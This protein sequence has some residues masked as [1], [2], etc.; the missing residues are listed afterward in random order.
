[1]RSGGLE[2]VECR[3]PNHVSTSGAL[4]DWWGLL[5]L[6]ALAVLPLRLAARPT[7]HP[8]A[9]PP[10][11]A[12]PG[13]AS[14][15]PATGDAKKTE[16][17]LEALKS[18]IERVA[19]QVSNDEVEKSRLNKELR[20]ADVSVGKARQ[21]LDGVRRQRAETAARRTSLAAEKKERESDL[22][23]ERDALAAQL[24]AAYMIGREEPLKLLLN[25]KDP[26]R[27]GR[28]FAYYGYFGRAR[29]GQIHEIEDNVQ[30]LAQLDA[31]LEAE[32]GK[33]AQLEKS[34]R[35]QLADLEEARQHRSIVLASLE[36]EAHTRAE[37]LE[38]LRTQQAGLEKLLKELRRALEKLPTDTNDA[39]ARLRG[40]LAWPVS[41]RVLAR[42]GETR[43]GGVKWDGVL[44]ATERGAPVRA[45]SPGRVIY[46]DWLPGLGLLTII[47][48][49]NGYMSL[50]GHNE[51]L[52]KAV[53]EQVAAGDAIASAGDSGGT[54]RPELYFE[55]RKAGRP[56]DPRPW[57]KDSAP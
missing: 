42:F 30:S 48:H 25:Q 41:G 40:K 13:P 21:G 56:I 51:Q 1:V 24:R 6:C 32:D 35:A 27:A 38:R 34:Q 19:R 33:L 29:A 4:G 11:P 37:S 54:P 12:A 26:E 52:Y 39:F 46:A 47:D 10:A 55:I 8:H 45:I 14:P 36:A 57:F 7:R 18:E 16:A 44:V 49:G 5:A 15:A 28:M 23:R 53:G 9:T 43:A 2:G 22:S 17:Q 3:L 50:Y 20:S 31:Q